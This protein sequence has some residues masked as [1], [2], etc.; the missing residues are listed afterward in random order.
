[1]A[2]DDTEGDVGGVGYGIDDGEVGERV[3][4]VEPV[5]A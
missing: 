3:I 5:Y 2:I 4:D 1:M